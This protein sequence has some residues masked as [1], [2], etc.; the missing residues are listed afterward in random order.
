MED[1]TPEGAPSTRSAR[2]AKKEKWRPAPLGALPDSTPRVS[3]RFV[4]SCERYG[5]A[6]KSLVSVAEESDAGVAGAVASTAA[7]QQ[8]AASSPQKAQAIAAGSRLHLSLASEGASTT[9]SSGCDSF[10]VLGYEELELLGNLGSG[11]SGFVEKHRHVRTG[12]ELALK[13]IQAGDVSEAQ[14]KA[15]LLELRTFAKCRSPHIVDFYGVFFHENSIHIALEYMD[16]GA[17]SAVLKLRGR[18]PE[19][20]LSIMTWQILDGLEYLHCEMHVIH[21]DIKP[22]NL[23]LSQA[24]ILKLTDFGVSGELE[25]DLEQK[26][27]VTFVGTMYY[28][29][30]ER[31]RGEPYSYDSDM[32]SLGVT[33]F[34]CASGRY[35][36]AQDEG[37]MRQLSFWELMRRIVEQEA[38]QLPAADDGGYSASLSDILQQMLQKEPRKRPSAALMK[39]HAWLGGAWP[40]SAEQRLELTSWCNGCPDAEEGKAEAPAATP[41]VAAAV[42]SLSPAWAASSEAAPPQ[43]QARVD[44][45]KGFA[46]ATMAPPQ[47]ESRPRPSGGDGGA[48]G[49]WASLAATA[50]SPF[51]SVR[52]AASSTASPFAASVRGA[53]SSS[54]SPFAASEA[55]CVSPDAAAAHGAIAIGSGQLS[56]ERLRLQG[57]GMEGDGGPDRV[58]STPLSA[59]DESRPRRPGGDG[60]GG[61]SGGWGN[62]A[63]MAASPFASVR[64]AGS[65]PRSPLAT[66]DAS[67]VS[68]DAT[69]AHGGSTH[70]VMA[71]GFGHFS[72]DWP[73]SQGACAEAPEQ[74]DVGHAWL[75][76]TPS[77]PQD[78]SRSRRLGNDG[79]SG[80]SGGWA[81]LA[82]MAASPF[83]SVRGAGSSTASPVAVSDASCVS[84]DAAA[85]RGGSS[86][87]AVAAGSGHFS[88]DWL[89][90][91]G[92][93]AE[94]EARPWPPSS[95]TGS[96]GDGC[97]GLGAAT[98][99]DGTTAA[100]PPSVMLKSIRGGQNPFGRP[101]NTP[102]PGR[103]VN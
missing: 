33:L 52:G 88:G 63:A 28:M 100:E 41:V 89:R 42:A 87:S 22:S 65:F 62:L 34:E 17:L 45:G 68:P 40:L 15:I 61:A 66:S 6:G 9:A 67:C 21:R 86:H 16:A 20:V 71:N 48:S 50:A 93:C 13:V 91:Q 29:S 8:A 75:R 38:P 4:A 2:R 99:G 12:R 57:R 23:L 79:D 85:A 70:N 56:G 5:V 3:D 37:S 7:P 43:P 18:V 72:G 58:R 24:G 14:R 1:S 60:D 92:G 36:Y 51:A 83:A 47:D 26:N 78:D 80:P 82:T 64:G 103:L 96:A 84:P 98:I 10:E 97:A 102:T 35:P 90:F 81:S 25:D 27:K 73:R 11:S 30:P 54:A 74:S 101:P 31:V 19:R 59:Q 69:T 49:G 76:P 53:G 77:L 39:T 32:W 46:R 55:S 44:T 94:E 95:G